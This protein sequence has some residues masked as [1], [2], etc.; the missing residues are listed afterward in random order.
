MCIRVIAHND[1]GNG[2]GLGRLMND[3]DKVRNN[4]A[5]TDN[6]IGTESD[7][8][9]IEPELCDKAHPG[10]CV[11]HMSKDDA[12]AGGISLILMAGIVAVS[13]YMQFLLTKWAVKA[14]LKETRP[15]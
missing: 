15:R 13:T 7:E 14:A 8:C 5:E 1:C 6:G 9:F 12:I 11:K 3:D 4:E 10:K 2:R